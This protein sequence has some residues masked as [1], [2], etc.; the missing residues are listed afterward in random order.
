MRLRPPPL[1]SAETAAQNIVSMIPQTSA[2]FG[3]YFT[4]F[5]EQRLSL[6]TKYTHFRQ[7]SL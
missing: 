6:K 5:P 7:K 4:R 3:R 1:S 2:P